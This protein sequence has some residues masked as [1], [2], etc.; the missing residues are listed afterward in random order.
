MRRGFTVLVDISEVET[1]DLECVP[2]LTKIM[3]ACKA[4]GVDTVVRIIP[5]PRKDIGLK[6]L[7]IVHYGRGVHVVTCQDAAEAERVIPSLGPR[8]DSTPSDPQRGSE[9]AEARTN[10]DPGP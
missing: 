8:L 2:D 1:M 3:D 7:S 4:A 5:D 10:L 9:I 6:I